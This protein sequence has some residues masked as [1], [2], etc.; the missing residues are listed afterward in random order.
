MLMVSIHFLQ[1][2]RRK[3]RIKAEQERL[4]SLARKHRQLHS[5][6]SPDY[7]G[8]AQQMKML[9]SHDRCPDLIRR[10]YG[11]RHAF[12]VS[13]ASGIRHDTSSPPDSRLSYHSDPLH[14]PI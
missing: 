9:S 12:C 7:A 8:Q 14:F 6:R 1:H 13:Q 2:R 4:V 5:R 10:L 11:C 3:A